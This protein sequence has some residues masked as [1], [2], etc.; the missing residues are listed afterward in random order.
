MKDNTK[1]L[2]VA[3]GIAAAG[4]Y[5]VTT[6]DSDGDGYGFAGGGGGV[7]LLPQ[8]EDAAGA[9]GDTIYNLPAPITDS[10]FGGWDD[11]PDAEDVIEGSKKVTES[12][13]LDLT[14]YD[15]RT[16]GFTLGQTPVV[17]SPYSIKGAAMYESGSLSK[18]ASPESVKKVGA[19][20]N[21]FSWD[22]GAAIENYLT[23]SQKHSM[24]GDKNYLGQTTTPKKTAIVKESI[25]RADR[26][27]VSGY[28][29]GSS[30]GFTSGG[31]EYFG[32]TQSTSHTTRTG[33]KTT[34]I[35]TK[36]SSRP[37][38]PD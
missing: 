4:L 5:V 20:W 23:W 31:R 1:N 22:R 18:K 35:T 7:P 29:F 32:P 3:T 16:T 25:L 33:L 2:I 17:P 36:K 34:L 14:H 13:S 15:P 27:N 6:M 24:M 19:W 9:G 26:A 37:G 30:G 38:S 8:L 10:P 12:P 21:P 28:R 11:M